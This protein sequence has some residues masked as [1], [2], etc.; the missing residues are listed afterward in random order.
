MHGTG[1]LEP[2]IDDS[3]DW[4]L[5]KHQHFNGWTSLEF[6]RDFES[7]DDRHDLNIEVRQIRQQLQVQF[8]RLNS[9]SHFNSCKLKNRP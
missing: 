6:R 1:N 4:F 3:Q 2:I 8:A 5:L 7:C 9:F